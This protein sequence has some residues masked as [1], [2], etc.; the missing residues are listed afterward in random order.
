MS[1]LV[2]RVQ[3]T[4]SRAVP[5]PFE[6]IMRRCKRQ[7]T[8]LA[9]RITADIEDAR[10]IAQFVFLQLHLK[11]PTFD[12]ER[13]IERWLYVVARN[14]ALQALRRRSRDANARSTILDDA[15][16]P[17]LEETVVRRE[18]DATLRA[19]IDGLPARD[20]RVL[21]LRDLQ[22]IPSG[23]IAAQLGVPVARVKKD[24][25]RARWRLRREILRRG[26]DADTL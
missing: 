8:V 1:H 4:P 10:D 5:E 25:E 23:E 18:R 12:D 16:P 15:P 9:Y 2:T 26:L 22:S 13:A 11:G 14:A 24:V 19:T 20:R 7:V 6:R 3:D 21:E 17:S